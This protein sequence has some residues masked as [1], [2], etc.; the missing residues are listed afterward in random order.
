MDIKALFSRK[1]SDSLDEQPTALEGDNTSNY[2][3][4]LV[5]AATVSAV[6]AIC[7]LAFKLITAPPQVE[8]EPEPDYEPVITSDFTKK[9]RS[10][11]CK[12][13]NRPLR[14]C[15]PPSMA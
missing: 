1:E 5:V 14:K 7:Y 8:I 11:L 4:N 15:K 13:N 2:K 3:K 12:H 10:R 6:F 9:T